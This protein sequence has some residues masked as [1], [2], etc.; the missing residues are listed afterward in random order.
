MYTFLK[1]LSEA[2]ILLSCLFGPA[3]AR[4]TFL[5]YFHFYLFF[6]SPAHIFIFLRP[7]RCTVQDKSFLKLGVKPGNNPVENNLGSLMK[8][9]KA[10]WKAGGEGLTKKNNNT[11]NKSEKEWFGCIIYTFPVARFQSY[12]ILNGLNS[13]DTIWLK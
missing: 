12:L 6:I 5:F 7:A 9:E 2:F 3:Y 10:G 1:Y 4:F 13:D 11:E 8:S